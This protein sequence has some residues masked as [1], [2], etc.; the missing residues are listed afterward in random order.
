[1]LKRYLPLIVVAFGIVACSKDKLNTRP[2]LEIKNI[3]TT[4]VLP[5]QQ[6]VINLNYKD[7]EGDLGSGLITY[8]RDR[9]NIKPIPDAASNDK[10]DTTRSPLP[11][12]PK[13]TSGEIQ[14]KIDGTFMSE[15][16][17]ENDTMTFKIYVTDVAGNVSDTLL[18]GPVVDKQN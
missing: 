13:T 17:F 4:D 18:V 9:L 15:D 7:K 14:L 6:L 12:F 16:P 10:A 5:G 1:M 2:S 3:N 8:I 11:D